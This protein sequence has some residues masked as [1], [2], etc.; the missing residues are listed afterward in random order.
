MASHSFDSKKGDVKTDTI[1]LLPTSSTTL[2]LFGLEIF[3]S[4]GF[5][6][7]T[8]STSTGFCK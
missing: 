7:V 8:V 5:G 3:L 1:C 2:S 6:F 4:L